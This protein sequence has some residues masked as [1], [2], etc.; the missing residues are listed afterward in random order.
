MNTDWLREYCMSF[1]GATEEVQW[2]DHLLFKVG[3]KIFV[4]SALDNTAENM[5]SMKCDPEIFDE[6]VE[7]EG[8]VPAPYLAKAKWIAVK[9][10]CRLKPAELKALIKTSYN[11]V[12]QKL[13]KR[14]KTEIQFPS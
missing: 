10:N 13:P 12:F 4:I 3:G 8:I 2:E 7:S 1:S 14:V 11:L 6:L 9:K 5:M